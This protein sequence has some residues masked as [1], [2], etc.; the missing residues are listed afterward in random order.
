MPARRK[1]RRLADDHAEQERADAEVKSWLLAQIAQNGLRRRRMSRKRRRTSRSP[2]NAS[3]PSNRPQQPAT[4][5]TNQSV[6]RPAMFLIQSPGSGPASAGSRDRISCGYVW[7]AGPSGVFY[8]EA[9][10]RK[11]PCSIVDLKTPVPR[12]GVFF[13]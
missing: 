1:A 5:G 2:P 4:R 7:T 6:T 13:F 8:D 3:P 12:T 9:I 11:S 10:E